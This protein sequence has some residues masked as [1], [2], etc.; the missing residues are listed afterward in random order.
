MK[1]QH[2]GNELEIG[3]DKAISDNDIS[4][5]YEPKDFYQKELEKKYEG[6][7]RSSDE[8]VVLGLCGGIAHKFDIPVS[9]V[10]VGM[11]I[12][13]FFIFGF[14]YAIG[15][16]LPQIPTKNKSREMVRV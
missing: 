4:V 13:M 16:F 15:F 12:A 14:I 5:H 7:Y 2:C 11:F 3:Y 8:K 10:R 9:T 1:C 6:F